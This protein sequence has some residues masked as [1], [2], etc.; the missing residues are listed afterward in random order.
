ML[1]PLLQLLERKLLQLMLVLLLK[2]LALLLE[3]QRNLVLFFAPLALQLL[4][5]L[6]VRLLD[7]EY[8]DHVRFLLVVEHHVVRGNNRCFRLV[9][10]VCFLRLG[11]EL[12]LLGHR[13][14]MPLP[15]LQ[16]LLVAHHCA[17][18][19]LLG[20]LLLALDAQLL[21]LLL[22]RRLG[23]ALVL[24][25]LAF[26]RLL[27]RLQVGLL[28]AANFLHFLRERL[29][30]QLLLASL[31]FLVQLRDGQTQLLALRFDLLQLHFA[32]ASFVALL[33]LLHRAQLAQFLSHVL[34]GQH[35]LR[36]QVLP[37]RERGAQIAA[38]LQRVGVGGGHHAGHNDLRR[39]S[40][41]APHLALRAPLLLQLG[42]ALGRLA[43]VAT[44]RLLATVRGWQRRHGGGRRGAGADR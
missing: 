8:F 21:D 16:L 10:H 30:H 17:R 3:A 40:V 25:E 37:R 26:V 35:L 12:V 44:R 9:R 33:L 23:F 1:V 32:Q 14:L 43:A 22:H 2:V 36:S 42:V 34:L 13:R 19:E 18:R 11:D 31:V 28:L 29:L 24:L 6:K 15:L 38:L 5:L 39:R 7:A 41:L 27:E 20:A 4:Q